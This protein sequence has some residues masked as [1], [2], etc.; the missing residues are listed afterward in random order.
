M[1]CVK[2]TETDRDAVCNA[3]SGGSREHVLRGNVNAHMGRG[4]FGRV[5]PIE[6]H[7]GRLVIG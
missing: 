4:T 2:T 6:E 1:N 3:E 7:F 5:C